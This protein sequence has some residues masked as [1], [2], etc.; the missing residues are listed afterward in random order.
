[1]PQSRKTEHETKITYKLKKIAIIDKTYL[2]KRI[3]LMKHLPICV[4]AFKV[5]EMENG[6]KWKV[7]KIQTS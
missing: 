3:H 4:P 1:M 7:E 5:I 6:L 2:F